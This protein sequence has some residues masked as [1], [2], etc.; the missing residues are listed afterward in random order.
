MRITII[1]FVLSL[2]LFC[3][4][5][6]SLNAQVD[7]IT[8]IHGKILGKVHFYTTDRLC[9]IYLINNN[10]EI[11]KYTPDGKETYRYSNTRLDRPTFI[12]ATDPFNLLVFYPDYQT[13][14]LLD[15]T[16]THTA[17]L[18]FSDFG[19]FNVNAVAFSSDNKLWVYD[20]LNFRL[21]KI[22]RNG[23]TIQESDDLS[24][25]LDSDFKPNFIVERE[26]K[27]FVN[28]P[29]VGILVFDAFGQ[30]VK[31]LD[32]KGLTDFQVSR[33][34][35]IFRDANNKAQIFQLRSLL[36]SPADLSNIVPS[37]KIQYQTGFL[38]AQGEEGLFVFRL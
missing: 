21:K 38:Y 16:M 3:S 14:I 27:V 35:L 9:N 37:G 29:D 10:Y 20:E 13:I 18:N 28:D 1:A 36:T 19:F 23:K 34:L 4:M 17:T 7:S 6:T 8:E 11:V 30:Y 33:N 25:L 26:Q 24:L 15:R 22:D 5:S 31:S 12:D 32:F 2:N